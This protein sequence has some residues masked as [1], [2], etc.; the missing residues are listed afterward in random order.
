MV[1]G[2][3]VRPE[4]LAIA[5]R[6]PVKPLRLLITGGSQGA[7]PVNRAFVDAMD[8]LALRK[9]E[10]SIVHQTGERDYDAV[11]TGYARREILPKS[12]RF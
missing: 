4:F 2:C 5:P 7:L 11:R 1:T 12:C 3:P 8:A 6:A 10:L 9:N